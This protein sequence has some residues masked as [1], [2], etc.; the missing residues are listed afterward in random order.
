MSPERE[1]A[2]AFE[3]RARAL[4]EQSAQHVSAPVR[5]R[6]NRARQAALVEA[7]RR[8][9]VRLW[10]SPWMPA[11]GALIAAAL[12]AFVLWPRGPRTNFAAVEASHATVEDLDLLADRDGLDLMKNGDGQFYEWAMAQAQSP[13]GGRTA[14]HDG[15]HDKH[16]G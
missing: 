5:S 8:R 2:A 1:G 16:S 11:T 12:I 3:A 9:S 15:A 7:D 6:L 4:L 13:S 10:R 14:E